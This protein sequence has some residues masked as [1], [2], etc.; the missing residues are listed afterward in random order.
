MV[1]HT[2]APRWCR[3]N[4]A[5]PKL[6]LKTLRL[7]VGVSVGARPPIAA[8]IVRIA[9]R[10]THRTHDMRTAKRTHCVSSY[11]LYALRFDVRIV[12]IREYAQN[13]V[14]ARI[15]EYRSIIFPTASL[16]GPP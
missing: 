15:R 8:P 4:A 7:H 13:F 3:E 9:F 12:R 10:R 16:P 14:S 2:H 6:N 5:R 1:M 11:A